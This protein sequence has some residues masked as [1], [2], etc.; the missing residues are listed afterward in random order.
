MSDL[1]GSQAKEYAEKTQR[2]PPRDSVDAILH[3]LDW[4]VALRVR[5]RCLDNGCGTGLGMQILINKYADRL[6]N[7]TRLAAADLSPGMVESVRRTKIANQGNKLW[8]KL[9]L[10]VCNVEAMNKFPDSCFSHVIAS[11]VLFFAKPE[12][13]FSEA[14]RI[15]QPGGVMGFTTFR[16]NQWLELR[17]VVTKIDP[18]LRPAPLPANWA[19]EAWIRS[20]LESAGFIDIRIEP[21]E[22]YLQVDDASVF[23][24]FLVRSGIPAM[25]GIFDSLAEEEKD[26]AVQLVVDE[27]A[28][29]YPDKPVRIPG[30]FLVSSARRSSD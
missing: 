13:A 5:Y 25:S 18:S 15:M 2:G 23:A 24:K 21:K 28:E 29:K 16:E 9:E 12:P 19:S 6:P 14:H 17:N 22:V 8:D 1:W 10:E 30:V 11:L 20:Q 4:F 27:I 3:T 26:R 7:H